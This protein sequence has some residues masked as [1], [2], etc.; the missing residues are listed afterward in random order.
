MRIDLKGKSFAGQPV[1]G[2]VHAEIGVGERVA[3][4]GKSGIGKS[5]LIRLIAGL[6]TN[7]DGTI[8]DIGHTA[9][10][11]QEPTLLPWRTA[12]AN[13]TLPT[14]C[15]PDLAQHLLAEVGLLDRRDAF[16]RQ[17]S[18]GQQRRL[19]LARALAAEPDLLLL[20]EAFASLDSDTRDR[21][22]EL[23]KKLLSA[24]NVGL[25]LATHDMDEANRL[26]SRVL[27]LSGSP[28]TLSIDQPLDANDVDLH[29]T[30]R[31]ALAE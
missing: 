15:T 24:R 12:L 29:Q 26:C 27:A 23:T 1:L 5:T 10:V 30:M 28:A 4:V 31:A 22:L 18:L 19:A 8:T 11:F 25:I 17:L 21:M 14:R 7:L 6:E 16:P 13:I 9:I 20:D 2:P 3:L